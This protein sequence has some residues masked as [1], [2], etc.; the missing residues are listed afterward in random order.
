MVFL[1]ITDTNRLLSYLLDIMGMMVEAG[2]EI[3]RV[4][5]SAK[6]VCSAYGIEKVDVYATTTNIIVS[7]EPREGHIKTH[8]R[9]ISKISTDIEKIDKLNSLVRRMSAKEIP[10]ETVRDEIGKIKELQ[11]HSPVAVCLF[12]LL[13]AVSFYL[14]FG[15]RNL[16]ELLVAATVGFLVGVLSRVLGYFHANKF[17]AR[18]AC[19]L[20]LCSAAYACYH[21]RVIDLVDYV[22]IGNIMVLI[23]GIGLTNA[24]R[25][26][27]T[28]DSISGTLRFIEAA[29]LALSIAGG[30][31]LTT[32]LFG[33]AV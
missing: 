9:R 15:G 8:T 30:Y 27:F 4:E 5:E 11:E 20:F 31:I 28:G 29:L 23:P 25:D 14:F 22:I 18:F 26:L 3:Y 13:I 10:L 33:G 12:Y 19:S 6:R 24:L 32:V 21:L 1:E 7:V 16:V 2:A 17:F